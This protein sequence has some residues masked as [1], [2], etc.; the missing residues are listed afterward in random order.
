[1]AKR[2]KSSAADRAAGSAKWDCLD[3]KIYNADVQTTTY[4]SLQLTH[5]LQLV[6]HPLY[7]HPFKHY[8]LTTYILLVC[9]N[10]YLYTLVKLLL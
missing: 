6:G 2:N 10:I 1:M 5:I 8:Q 9:A 7:T 4:I 3:T